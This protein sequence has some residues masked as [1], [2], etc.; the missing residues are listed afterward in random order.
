MWDFFSQLLQQSPTLIVVIF[1]L[2]A[3]VL[4]SLSFAA[5]S[6]VKLVIKHKVELQ[7]GK[8]VKINGKDS[9]EGEA[10]SEEETTSVGEEDLQTFISTLSMVIDYSVESGHNSSLRRQKLYDAQMTYIID[11]FETIRTAIITAYTDKTGSTPPVLLPLLL[12]Q[13]FEEALIEKLRKICQA[14]KLAE[15]T[16]EVVV[17]NNRALIEGAFGKIEYNLRNYIESLKSTLKA[18]ILLKCLRDQ[19]E[20]VKK[21]I[22]SSLEYAYDEAVSAMEALRHEKKE[23]NDK[24]NNALK[25]YFRKENLYKELPECWNDTLP[26]NSVVKGV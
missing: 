3:A 22:V 8:N 7:L 25:S 20:T 21:A 23:Y 4:I 24:V 18:D 1:T 17:E 2:I 9:K 16:R 10:D 6:I 12:K 5:I 19:Q 11:K 13:S 26:P 15:K 14:D